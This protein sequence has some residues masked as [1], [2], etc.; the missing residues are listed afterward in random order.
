MKIRCVTEETIQLMIDA[1]G[2]FYSSNEDLNLKASALERMLVL[3]SLLRK[4]KEYE[5]KNES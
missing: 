5:V 2:S 1:E 3:T 4:V